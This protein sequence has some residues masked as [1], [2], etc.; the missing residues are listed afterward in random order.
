MLYN[1][2]KDTFTTRADVAFFHCLMHQM[3]F[4]R[5]Y[6]A[7]NNSRHFSIDYISKRGIEISTSRRS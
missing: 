5:R 2:L 7:A 1:V 6:E 3:L 4:T